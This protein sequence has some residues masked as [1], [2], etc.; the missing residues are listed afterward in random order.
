LENFNFNLQKVL[1]YRVGIEEKKKLEYVEA[2]KNMLR[3][4]S[5]LNHLLEKRTIAEHYIS[6]NMTGYEC[7]S[8]TRYIEN[9]DNKILDQRKA[10]NESIKVLEIKIR[11]LTQCMS[12][13]K[14]L[15]KLREKAY[16]EF[17]DEANKRE[18]KLNDD[19][20]LHAFVRAERR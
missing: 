12:D 15:E 17:H 20:A 7:Q 9:L 16:Q 3:Q 1:D 4:E 18:Q 6:S 19:F 10:L 14:V 5:I 2:Q 8:L 13:R 11:E